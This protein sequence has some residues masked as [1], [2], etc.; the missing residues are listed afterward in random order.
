MI[1]E[2]LP[3]NLATSDS[4]NNEKEVECEYCEGT[5]KAQESCC[6]DRLNDYGICKTCQEHCDTLG[7]DCNMCNG[8]GTILV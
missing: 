6:G 1:D 7:D 3:P 5:G 8:K 2:N 4:F